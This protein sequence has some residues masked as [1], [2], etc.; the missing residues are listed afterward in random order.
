MLVYCHA[1]KDRTGLINALVLATAG[2]QHTTIAQDYA[3]SDRCLQPLYEA[4]L[5]QERDAA[6][7]LRL[8]RQ[9]RSPLNAARPSTMLATLAHLDE[10]HGGATSYLRR[11]GVASAELERLRARLGG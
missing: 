1:G 5:Q 6:K 7:R 11:S 4:Q 3:L 10:R 2:V 9:L 8:K